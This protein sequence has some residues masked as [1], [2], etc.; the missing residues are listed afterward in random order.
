MKKD[1]TK[2]ISDQ[3][4]DLPSYHKSLIKDSW[5]RAGINIDNFQELYKR[6]INATECDKCK[7]TFVKRNQRC[8]DHDHS[9]G[10]FRHFLC[11]QCNSKYYVSNYKNNKT[12]YKNIVFHEVNGQQYFRVGINYDKKC[13]AKHFNIT[14]YDIEDAVKWRDAKRLELQID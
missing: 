10:F 13:I 14:K 11:R 7:K 1:L 9:T 3:F 8:L 5:R 6:Y 2:I 12:G 4:G